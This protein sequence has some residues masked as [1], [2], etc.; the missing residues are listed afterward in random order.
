MLHS[1]PHMASKSNYIFIDLMNEFKPPPSPGFSSA[2]LN[3]G[4]RE[5]KE[6]TPVKW[7][8]EDTSRRGGRATPN[9][10]ARD[11][12]DLPKS[13]RRR[14]STEAAPGEV[15]GVESPTKAKAD[16]ARQSRRSSKNS[17]KNL[18]DPTKSGQVTDSPPSRTLPDVPKKTRRKNSK[19]C[20]V[21]GRTNGSSRSKAQAVELDNG[22]ESGFVGKAN[23]NNEHCHASA[24]SAL[25]EVEQG[26]TRIS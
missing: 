7:V 25:E 13:S 16:K 20:S 21:N 2:P 15:S 23:S 12:P 19:E 14:S 5:I 1:L 24:L 9:S 22:S 4:E 18:L 3:H 8:S 26:F 6:K 11:L 17:A 10:P